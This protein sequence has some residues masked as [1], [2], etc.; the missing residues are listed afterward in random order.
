MKAA[1]G[2]ASVIAISL[3]ARSELCM[4]RGLC[5]PTWTLIPYERHFNTGQLMPRRTED[6][7]SELA[8]VNQLKPVIEISS[9]IA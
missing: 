2:L 7:M 8:N 9:P 6:L 5:C 1:E 4:K 3:K